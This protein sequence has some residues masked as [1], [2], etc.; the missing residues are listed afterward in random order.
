MKI[1]RDLAS[2]QSQPMLKKMLVNSFNNYSKYMPSWKMGVNAAILS[3]RKF[4]NFF[5]SDCRAM[6]KG[7]SIEYFTAP[8]CISQEKQKRVQDDG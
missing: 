3:A 1:W 6:I 2:Y 8:L 4:A 7:L 5:E